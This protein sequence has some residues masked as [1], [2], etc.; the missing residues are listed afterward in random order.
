MYWR[1]WCCFWVVAASFLLWSGL[2]PV[3]ASETALLIN[4]LKKKNIITQQEADEILKELKTAAQQEKTAI[5][6]EVKAEIKSEVKAEV[7]QDIKKDAGKGAFLPS[8]SRGSSSA[9]RSLPNGIRKITIQGSRA[10][11]FPQTS[12]RPPTS[13]P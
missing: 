3:H 11:A 4:L 5:K 13:L 2:A 12:T 6:K 7:T 8:P 9:V 10:T 1:K